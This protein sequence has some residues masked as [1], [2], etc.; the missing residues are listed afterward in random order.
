MKKILKWVLIV[1]GSLA[2]VAFLGFLYFIPPFELL[3][4]EA[5]IQPHGQ[6]V[7]ASL[8]SIAD[9]AQRL[10]A[11]RGRYIVGGNVCNDCH[12]PIGEQG[13][14]WDKFLAGGVKF[15]SKSAGTA[16]ARNLTPD[17]ETGLA[18]RTDEQVKRVL[19]TGVGPEG[20]I[21]HPTYMP[22]P[23]FTRFTE[24]DRHAVL[25]YLRNIKSVNH[26]IPPFSKESGDEV[27]SFYGFDYG[28][29]PEKQ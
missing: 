2:V 28:K 16:I 5:F 3:P 27:E 15:S 20:R 9:P 18:Q 22:W 23:P 8:Q 29:H 11:E 24:E 17:P 25:V 26:E 13:P 1:A 10:L 4:R 6:A 19:R 7:D 12:T 21:F 14:I